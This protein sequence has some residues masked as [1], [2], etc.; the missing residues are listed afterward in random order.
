MLW[1]S[2]LGVYVPLF[3]HIIGFME[4]HVASVFRPLSILFPLWFVTFIS[5]ISF[6]IVK[7]YYDYSVSSLGLAAH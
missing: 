2:F 7:W 6:P 3:D 1:L 4:V 5:S